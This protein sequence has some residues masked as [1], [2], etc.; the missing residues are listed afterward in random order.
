MGADSDVA[1]SVGLGGGLPDSWLSAA[2]DKRN[3]ISLRSTY[4]CIKLVY[5]ERFFWA[6]SKVTVIFVS[7]NLI[8]KI[9]TTLCTVLTT[10]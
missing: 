10:N 2:V 7:D 8:F 5:E 9:M 6:T 3:S 4:G 1:E